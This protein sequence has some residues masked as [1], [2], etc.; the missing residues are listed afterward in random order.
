MDKMEKI[1]F[2][3][4]K[5]NHYAQVIIDENDKFDELAVGEL[6]FYTSLRRMLDGK[7]SIQDKGTMDAINDFLQEMGLVEEGRTFYE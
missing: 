1:Q 7:G 5:I 2:V 3:E 6:I 4:Y